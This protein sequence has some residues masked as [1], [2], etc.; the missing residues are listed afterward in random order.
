MFKRLLSIILFA[1]VLI[2]AEAK[3]T[4]AV[5]MDSVQILIGQQTGVT[6]TVQMPAKS[7][8]ELPSFQGG[9]IT[10]GVI[11][12]SA[13]K[14][15]TAETDNDQIIVTE[16]Y[17]IT[18]F[19]EK[20]YYL[21]PF[22]VRVDGKVY[23][24]NSLALKVLTMDVDTLHKDQFFGPKDVVDNPFSWSDWSLLF[25]L[26]VMV[27]LLLA[28]SYY[29][30]T[31]YRDNKPIIV[32]PKIIERLLPHQ[33]AM[34]NIERIKADKKWASDNSKEYYT[35][36]TDT[37]RQY[38]EERYGFSAMEMTSSEIID[39]LS[40]VNDQKA[41]EELKELF[42]TADLVKFA[43]YN[44]LINENDMNLVTAIEYI[45]STKIELDPNAKPKEPVVSP[46]EKRGRKASL[47]LRLTIIVLLVIAAVSLIYIGYQAFDMLR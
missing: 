6:L 29:L 24:S 20:L 47:A 2:T 12:A 22:T 11:V 46:E 35:E 39:R 33:K 10:P 23:K 8:L 27:V 43:K 9:M 31:R 38:I 30:Y 19:D 21:P 42:Q 7:R 17:K 14:P 40:K 36:L 4:V 18:S 44:T 41:I 26:S 37:L 15:D 16:F 3:V 5:K 32:R 34:R 45:N 1:T 25:W 13:A 28:A